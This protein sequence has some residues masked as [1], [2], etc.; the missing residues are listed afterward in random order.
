MDSRT[1]QQCKVPPYYYAVYWLRPGSVLTGQ[2]MQLTGSHNGNEMRNAICVDTQTSIEWP[3]CPFPILR[4]EYKILS[5]NYALN[6][7]S[8]VHH[9]VAVSVSLVVPLSDASMVKT[10]TPRQFS[11]FVIPESSRSIGADTFSSP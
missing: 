2:K 5:R 4:C 6:D 11:F 10:N 8:N 7:Q 3:Y 9:T 1:T